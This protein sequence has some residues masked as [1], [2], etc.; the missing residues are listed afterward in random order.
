MKLWP[1][2]VHWGAPRTLVAVVILLL[3]A[4]LPMIAHALDSDYY[5]SFGTR[6]LIY[7]LAAI[8]LNFILG[9]GGMVSLGHAMYVLLG[10][11]AVAIPASHGLTSGW[12]QLLIAVSTTV[13]LSAAVGAVALRTSG[14]AFIMITLA[15]AQMMFFGAVSLKDYGGDDG[16]TVNARSLLGAL[17]LSNNTTLYYVSLVTVLVA[18][19]LS[20]RAVLS[21]F[22]LVLRSTKSNPRR[23]T[24]LG[25]PI[26]RY[27]LT[28]YVASAVIC[29]VA[30]VLLANLTKF[31]SPSYGA[32]TL[33]GE[34]IVIVILGGLGTIFGPVVGA[35][36]LLVLEEALPMLIEAV[37]P[38]YKTNWMLLLG[39]FIFIIALVLKRGVFGSL[40]P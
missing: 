10:A 39:L 20:W 22:G 31:A 17:D 35:I 14:I 28:A 37:L 19:Y 1:T 8:G 30:G 12:L 24:A 26:F 2:T 34:L 16:L 4:M 29:A 15:F 3:L 5:V 33:S 36:I 6:V 40:K 11:Y 27:Q 7:A 23:A 21:P 18:L 32:W 38:D 13:A 9:F 25:H